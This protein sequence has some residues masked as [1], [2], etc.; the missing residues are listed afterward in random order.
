MGG[1]FGNDKK[2]GETNK[3][4]GTADKV[5]DRG[6]GAY[7]QDR[8]AMQDALTNDFGGSAAGFM[9]KQQEAGRQQ[10]AQSSQAAGQAAGQQAAAASRMAGGGRGLAALQ[11]AQ[12]A[13]GSASQ[14]YMSGMEAG[15]NR[16]AQ[17]AESRAGQRQAMLNNSSNLM[18]GA[19]AGQLNAANSQRSGAEKA[20]GGMGVIGQGLAGIGGLVTGL[21]SDENLKENKEMSEISRLYDRVTKGATQ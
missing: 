15:A 19:A 17:S 21:F 18:S 8:A 10:G 9:A 1:L 5:V 14:N 6:I 12:M 3:A 11:G 13:G 2:Q 20:A 16:Y 7:D 4:T